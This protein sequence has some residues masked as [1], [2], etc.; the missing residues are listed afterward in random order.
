MMV[1]LITKQ[2]K[3]PLERS[4]YD[5]G[6]VVGRSYGCLSRAPCGEAYTRAASARIVRSEDGHPLGWPLLFCSLSPVAIRVHLR[7]LFFPDLQKPRCNRSNMLWA[8]GLP[9]GKWGPQFDSRSSVSLMPRLRRYGAHRTT[10][11]VPILSIL[12]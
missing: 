1:Y 7:H 12:I 10:I 8:L 6:H 4:S 2:L 5:E 3:W 11:L 9:N